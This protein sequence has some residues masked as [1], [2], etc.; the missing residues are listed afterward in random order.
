MVRYSFPVGLF[1]PLQHAGLSRRSFPFAHSRE[2][3]EMFERPS[4]AEPVDSRGFAP[5]TSR[6]LLSCRF[7]LLSPA[8]WFR[9]SVNLTAKQEALGE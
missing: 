7:R 1:H 9:A 8:R 2:R 4:H 3:M 5:E 6:P